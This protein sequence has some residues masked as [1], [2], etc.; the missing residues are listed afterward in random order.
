MV[1]G[2]YKNNTNLVSG[3]KLSHEQFIAIQHLRDLLDIKNNACTLENLIFFL[4]MLSE[5][6]KAR[7]KEFLNWLG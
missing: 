1:N 4:Q 5:N 6:I 2:L 3:P 7:K